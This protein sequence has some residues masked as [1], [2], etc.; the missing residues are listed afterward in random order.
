MC[1]AIYK[2]DDMHGIIFNPYYNLL[3][4]LLLSCPYY[5][6]E[7]RDSLRE[8]N[9]WKVPYLVMAK[10][11][12]LFVT[13]QPCVCALQTQ[14]RRQYK[15]QHKRV[16]ARQFTHLGTSGRACGHLGA[17]FSHLLTGTKKPSPTYPVGLLSGR[18]K[19]K[20]KKTDTRRR[21]QSTITRSRKFL[22]LQGPRSGLPTEGLGGTKP[23]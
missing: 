10:L 21:K 5:R 2:A 13:T 3:G 15:E 8:R 22:A 18:K 7:N 17:W 11:S 16:P 4:V 20:K 1:W 14:Y 9:T 23:S 6:R 19:K 12:S